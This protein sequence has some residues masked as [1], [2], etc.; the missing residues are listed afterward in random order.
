MLTGPIWRELKLM[1]T[2]KI[3]PTYTVLTPTFNRAHTLHRAYESLQRQ[4]MHGFEWIVVDDG[5]TDNTPE[6]LASWEHEASFPITW[7]RYGVNRGRNAAVNSGIELTRGEYI[8]ILD[9]DDELL[10]DAILKIDH[11]RLK[12]GIDMDENISELRFRY[13]Y[14]HDENIIVGSHIGDEGTRGGGKSCDIQKKML[15]D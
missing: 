3:A 14:A 6:L 9:S 15:I 1:N 11:W 12:T 7:C 8:L 10:D 2:S 13:V 4:T 5:S